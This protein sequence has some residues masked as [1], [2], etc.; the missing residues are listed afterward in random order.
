[1]LFLVFGRDISFFWKSG[2]NGFEVVEHEPR[3]KSRGQPDGSRR[4]VSWRH[5]NGASSR[6]FFL[7]HIAHSCFPALFGVYTLALL[8]SPRSRPTC[9]C[10]RFHNQVDQMRRGRIRSGRHGMLWR[11][12]TENTRQCT[13]QTVTNTEDSTRATYGMVQAR[14]ISRTATNMKV[15]SKVG[16]SMVSARTG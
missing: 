3:K 7:C 10:Y 8:H 4:H 2:A 15:N 9:A 13:I 5:F 6:L 12:N 1:M 14:C 11:T 16:C